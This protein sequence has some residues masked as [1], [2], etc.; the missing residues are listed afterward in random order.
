MSNMNDNE[1]TLAEADG[2]AEALLDAHEDLVAVGVDKD[3]A[4]EVVM[5]IRAGQVR[6]VA[7]VIE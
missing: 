1:T 6:N 4:A 2:R 5:A 7:M 3:L